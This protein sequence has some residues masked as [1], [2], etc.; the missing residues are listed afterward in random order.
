VTGD[1]QKLGFPGGRIVGPSIGV[2]ELVTART[3]APPPRRRRSFVA[4]QTPAPWPCPQGLQAHQPLDPMQTAFD[5]VCQQV[6]PDT[7]CAVGPVAG[8][9]ACLHLLAHRLVT[10]GSGAGG[11]VQPCMEARSRHAH[12]IA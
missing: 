2:N 10:P 11:S 12:R 4:R 1:D 6:S 3:A 8:K 7:P 9:E 5:T